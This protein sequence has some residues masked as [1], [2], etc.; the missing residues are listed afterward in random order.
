[1]A[2]PLTRDRI[3][4]RAVE[5]VEEAGIEALSLRSLGRDLGVSA[6]ALYDHMTSKEDLLRAVA[7][8]GYDDLFARATAAGVSDPLETIHRHAEA[9][10]AF[11]LERPGL[12]SLMFRFRPDAVAGPASLELPSATAVFNAAL[13][14]FVEAV[15]QGRLTGDPLKMATAAWAAIHGVATVCL[16]GTDLAEES[17]LCGMV[18]DGLLRGWQP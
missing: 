3:V 9:Y 10:V 6:P 8:V 17:W 15:D 2:E 18:L 12:F 16:L 1:V 11:A 7:D 4:A 13:A 5:I 14:P